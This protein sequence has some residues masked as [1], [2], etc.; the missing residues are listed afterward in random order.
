MT[1]IQ[2]DRLRTL[3]KEYLEY[4]TLSQLE[5]RTGIA[6]STLLRLINGESLK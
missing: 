6:R 4:H 2:A 1:E 3:I 5:K